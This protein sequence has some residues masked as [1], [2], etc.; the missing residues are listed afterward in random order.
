MVRVSHL[1]GGVFLDPLCRRTGLSLGLS[2][3]VLPGLVQC[4]GNLWAAS[5]LLRLA[6]IS[7]STKH[8]LGAECPN[9]PFWA[10][11]LPHLPERWGVGMGS[12]PGITELRTRSEGGWHPCS[13]PSPCWPPGAQGE[14]SSAPQ[15]SGQSWPG[16]GCLCPYATVCQP[17]A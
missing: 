7:P 16:P 9:W 17:P 15:E 3:I 11:C 4:P 6:Y 5:A 1:C 14:K 8:P 10:I 2:L 12:V 13:V